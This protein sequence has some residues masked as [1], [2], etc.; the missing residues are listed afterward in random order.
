MSASAVRIEI[1]T[2]ALRLAELGPAW[3]AL[4][5]EAGGSVFQSHGWITAWRASSRE[6]ASRGLRIALGWQGETLV[7]V[8]ALAVT[9]WRG[10][11]VLEW[12]AKEHTDYCDALVARTLDTRK[13][14][15]T[16]WSAV[17]RAGGFDLAYLS[18]LLPDA[19]MLP[20]RS[21]P[22]MGVAL[23]HR[24][25]TSLRVRSSWSGGEAW[26]S[27]QTKKL[28]Q[29]YRRSR[30]QLGETGEVRFRVLEPG[31]ETGPIVER[32]AAMK[33]DWLTRTGN[34]S[35]LLADEAAPLKA[36]VD[37]LADRGQLRLCVVECAGEVVAGCVNIEERGRLMAFFAAYDFTHERASVGMLIMADYIMDAFDA[38]IGEIDF[39]CGAEEY[40]RKL[41]NAE[42][43]LVSYVAARTLRGR[44]ALLADGLAF[45][46]RTWREARIVRRSDRSTPDIAQPRPEEAVGARAARAQ[47]ASSGPSVAG[48]SQPA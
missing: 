17:K 27:G 15:A 3:D 41:A 23:S 30:K 29:N 46:L 22:G 13:T 44:A 39:L 24:T 34:A 8:M 38:G 40:K 9:R 45:R 26:M 1:V 37:V 12:A 28:R 21:M 7:A 35:S 18:H 16:L 48:R 2:D 33:R 5:L 11:R 42:V 20:L 6:A 43:E 10:L 31:D 32:L 4:V 47:T 25:E 36:F 19:A 14:V